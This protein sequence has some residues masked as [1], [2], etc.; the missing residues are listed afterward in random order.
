MED[1]RHLGL[2]V[3]SSDNV[4]EA[5]L[6]HRLSTNVALHVA[7][8]YLESTT[9][10]GEEKMLQEELGPAA[11][12]LSSVR[13][14]LAIFG[15]TSAA[16]LHGLDGDAEI[17]LQ[18]TKATGCRCITVVQA[19]LEEIRRFKTQSLFLVT[20]YVAE[21][22]KRLME[23]FIEAGLPVTGAEGLGLDDD[24]SIGKVQPNEIMEYVI[25]IVRQQAKTPPDSVFISCTTFRAF[26][27]AEELEKELGIPV[28]TSNRSVF[29]V[30]QRYLNMDG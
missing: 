25:N 11:R 23:T 14:E 7:R 30:I 5:D 17:A 13:P 2:L 9:V 8:M 3:P 27:V 24:L 15:C 18:V 10:A 29:H 21:I 28:I 19:A 4:M 26:E 6:C 22:T 1:R 12:R 20:P 16:A